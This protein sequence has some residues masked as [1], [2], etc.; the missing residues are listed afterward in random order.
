MKI[1]EKIFSIL[2]GD[3]V[4]SGLGAE[5]MRGVVGVSGLKIINL[6][7]TFFIAVILAREL[8][9]DGY[10]IYTFVLSLITLISFFAYVGIPNLVLREVAKYQSAARWGMLKG[11]LKRSHQLIGVFSI[12]VVSLVISISSINSSWGISKDLSLV[13][14]AIPMIIFLAINA[15]RVSILQGLRKIVQG[16]IPELL[17]RPLTFLVIVLICIESD[18][19][20]STTAIV[21]Q[22]IAT[23][24]A[25]CV[26][27]WLLIRVIPNEVSIAVPEY[28]DKEWLR[29]LVPFS[30]LVGVSLLNTE[31]AIIV[32]GILSDDR[33][34]GLYRVASQVA[35]MVALS[36]IIINSVIAPHITRLYFEENIKKLQYMIVQSARA[37]LITALPLGCFFIFAGEWFLGLVFG[38]EYQE[39]YVP[40]IILTIGHLVNAATGSVGILLNLTGHE[41]ATLMGLLISLLI[42]IIMLIVL[43]PYYGLIGASAAISAGMIV[44]NIYLYRKVYMFIGIRSVAW[45]RVMV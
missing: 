19:L 30:L 24:V 35:A 40:L 3:K 38:Y 23:F 12:I 21:S 7:V 17:I 34:V 45:A 9:P 5:L 32:L 36:L 22:M 14:L 28:S 44:L 4:K 11:L 16:Q 27:A 6:V 10:G 37:V 31:V 29:S 39:A 18:F 26:G 2:L 8:K 1:V 15:L 33:S 43:I 20:T 41:R 25:L 13:L 42:S